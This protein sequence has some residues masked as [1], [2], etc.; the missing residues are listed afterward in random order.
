M[1]QGLKD[2]VDRVVRHTYGNWIEGLTIEA[3]R[4]CW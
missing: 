4:T 3:Y 2:E 1:P